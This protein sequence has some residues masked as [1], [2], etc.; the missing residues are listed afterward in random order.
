LGVCIATNID[1]VAIRHGIPLDA[2][3]LTVEKMLARDPKRVEALS[4]IVHGSVGIPAS[5]LR[6]LE[7]VASHCLVHRNLHPA[8]RVS[9]TFE[10][11]AQ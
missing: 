4:V 5:V 3:S 2:L 7:R 1:T 8:I 11:V 10:T 9:V 6:R